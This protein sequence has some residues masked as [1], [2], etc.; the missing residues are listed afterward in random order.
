MA[1]PSQRLIIHEHLSDAVSWTNLVSS[2]A[3]QICVAMARNGERRWSRFTLVLA[4]SEREIFFGSQTK[5]LFRLAYSHC[6]CSDVN[7]EKQQE[8][9]CLAALTVCMSLVLIVYQTCISS[10]MISHFAVKYFSYHLLVWSLF[11]P[12]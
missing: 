8:N 11:D 1:H 9:P 7:L 10:T 12:K 6:C 2:S 4:M 3:K 5:C